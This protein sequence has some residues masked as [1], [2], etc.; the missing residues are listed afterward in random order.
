MF[1]VFICRYNNPLSVYLIKQTVGIPQVSLLLQPPPGQYHKTA[2]WNIYAERIEFEQ[3]KRDVLKKPRFLSFSP[4]VVSA[5]LPPL[6]QLK[7]VASPAAPPGVICFPLN[8]SPSPPQTETSSHSYPSVS[9]LLWRSRREQIRRRRGRR[10][11]DLN[12]EKS[13][14]MWR[15]PRWEVP[16]SLIRNTFSLVSGTSW[17]YCLAG[18]MCALMYSL[19]SGFWGLLKLFL[20]SEIPQ[21]LD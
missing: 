14:P 16:G 6:D 12:P 13:R 2:L 15:P 18:P 21:E 10:R 7:P 3:C 8:Y 5:P 1:Y 17:H 20:L 9:T 4:A 11:R 19:P